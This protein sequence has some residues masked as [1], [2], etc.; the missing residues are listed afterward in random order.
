MVRNLEP[1]YGQ[2]QA[3]TG[4][5]SAIKLSRAGL[6]EPTRPVGSFL[7]SGPTGVGK[8]EIARRLAKLANAP[9]L[10][11]EA[12][13]YT[14]VGYYGRDVESMVRELVEETR[15]DPRWLQLELTETAL[16]HNAELA[17]Q[18]LDTRRTAVEWGLS[19]RHPAWRGDND[20][21]HAAFQRW[22]EAFESL[23]RQKGW[24]PP[25]ELPGR[26]ARALEKGFRPREQ[27]IDLV[28]FDEFN[29]AQ[30]ALLGALALA[31]AAAT[32]AGI[33]P[34]WRMARTAPAS[35]MREE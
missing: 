31:V 26:L 24:L 7:F 10:K 6:A 21:N 30:S 34:S 17:A 35:A 3:I 25:E 22:N 15:V 28:G 2:D 33:Y 11:V 4:L 18:A 9:F 20:E 12:T 1:F 27:R 29:P 32:L 5:V 14:E 23:C 13:K 19:L 8:T 16:L